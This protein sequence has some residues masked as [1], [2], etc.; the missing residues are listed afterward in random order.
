MAAA[1]RKGGL[2]REPL[3]RFKRWE[4]RKKNSQ[5]QKRK[6]E[7]DRKSTWSL[8]WHGNPG[9]WSVSRKES[10]DKREK[11]VK[12]LRAH[13]TEQLGGP[14]ILIGAQGGQRKMKGE[15][16]YAAQ[17]PVPGKFGILGRSC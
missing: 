8:C 2:D 3:P 12:G 17:P 7:R 5:R 9:K 1:K 6:S 16:K 15:E 4:E 13:W 10:A 11:P 14:Q